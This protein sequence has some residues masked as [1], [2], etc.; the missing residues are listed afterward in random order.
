MTKLFDP[1]KPVQTR[2][3]RKAR[4]LCTD[5]K[6][7]NGEKIIALV[8]DGE[9]A[10]ET[11]LFYFYDGRYVKYREDHRDLM[12]VPDRKST[13]ENVYTES[14]GGYA[15]SS[16]EIAHERCHL[17]AD[18]IGFLER[19]YEDGKFV[20]CVFRPFSKEVKS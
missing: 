3:G 6:S 10:H 9:G 18:L 14:C 16:K 12:N 15:Y 20:E 4:I 19:I 5:R 1:S 7:H 8:D 17:R 11:V 2:D 13:W